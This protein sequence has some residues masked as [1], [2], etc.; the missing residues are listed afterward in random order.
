MSQS[1]Q[2]STQHISSSD[3]NSTSFSPPKQGHF[4]SSPRY[5]VTET[6]LQ[7]Q[8]AS[9]G[10]V[11]IIGSARACNLQRYQKTPAKR[12]PVRIITLLCFGDQFKRL[13]FYPFPLST[14]IP[15]GKHRFSSDH[16]SKALLGGVSTWMGDCLGIPRVVNF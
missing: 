1:E 16:Q 13:N 14:T 3:R 8:T 11:I 2:Q 9:K 5:C 15:Q 6:A 10:C 4:F 12:L 7:T